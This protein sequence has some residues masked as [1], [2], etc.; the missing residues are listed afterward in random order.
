MVSYLIDGIGADIPSTCA[1]SRICFQA[2]GVEKCCESTTASANT[3]PTHGEIDAS[4]IDMA[5]PT[6]RAF[7]RRWAMR[8]L[9]LPLQGVIATVLVL[10]WAL[11]RLILR[12]LRWVLL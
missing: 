5:N 9:V 11:L 8:S 2:P 6:T 3:F 12:L 4:N 1:N 7:R 10:L